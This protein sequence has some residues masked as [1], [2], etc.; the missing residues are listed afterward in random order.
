MT[1]TTDPQKLAEQGKQA[2][3][4][5]K[6]DQAASAFS[7]AASAYQALDDAP[8]AAEMKNNL[9]VALFQA[10][11]AQAAYDAAAGTELRE[12]AERSGGR[13]AGAPWSEC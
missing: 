7:E 9:S 1:M 6:Y 12:F 3:S 8:N 5:K 10:G 11:D 13:P 4:A 2:F